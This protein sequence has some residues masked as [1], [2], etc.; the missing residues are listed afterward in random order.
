M[1]VVYEVSVTVDAEVAADFQHWL[2]AH[3]DEVCRLP[4]FVD[5]EV[6]EVIEPAQ[7]RRAYRVSYSLR[8]HAA[9]ADYLRDHAPRMRGEGVSRFGDR[10]GASRR[11]LR[12]PRNQG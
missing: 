4:G 2:L 3:V 8:D 12:E 6:L 1:T 7:E 10:F 11:V 9:L 5:A